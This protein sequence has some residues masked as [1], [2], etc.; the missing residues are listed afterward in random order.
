MRLGDL[1]I[2]GWR[3]KIVIEL[4]RI[5]RAGVRTKL[6]YEYAAWE[7][8]SPIFTQFPIFIVKAFVRN[9]ALAIQDLGTLNVGNLT[10]PT[11]NPVQLKKIYNIASLTSS[12]PTYKKNN[13]K[14]QEKK[15]IHKTSF[16]PLIINPTVDA[17]NQELT[18]TW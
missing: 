12:S 18:K 5:P 10:S 3:G 9:L 7:C 6:F 11:S 1:R 14:K 15:N 16:I 13:F 17:R 4:S 2:L 8:L